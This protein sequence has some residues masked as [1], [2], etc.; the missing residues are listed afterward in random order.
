MDMIKGVVCGAIAGVICA[1][2]W[3]A[4][5]HFTGYELG[6]VAWLVGGGVGLGVA[7]GCR[8]NTSA[9]TGTAAAI[10]ALA[11]IVGGRYLVMHTIAG[12]AMD[13]VLAAVTIDDAN[14]QTYMARA[15][16]EEA[17]NSGRSP[18]W[19]E[20]KDQ[21]NVT[22]LDDYPREI[23]ADVRARYAA[24]DPAAQDSYK[25]A[26]AQSLKHELTATRTQATQEMF[27][28]SLGPLDFL[29][30]VLALYTAYRVGS[31]TSAEGE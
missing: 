11:S 31:G 27:V 28:R 7:V 5:A 15:L 21:E 3:A 18:V 6:L 8:G 26:I 19:P 12:V 25:A 14:A 30:A 2:V 22:S 13:K 29:F 10:I 4:I 1:G 23:A 17:L 16:V 9:L 24:M 20:G